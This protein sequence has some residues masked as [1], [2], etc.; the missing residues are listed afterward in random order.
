MPDLSFRKFILAAAWRKYWLGETGDEE[1]EE[2]VAEIQ[3]RVDD[4]LNLALALGIEV[5]ESERWPKEVE[6][7]GLGD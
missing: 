7:E 3:A 2:S 6:S 5:G 1:I 4:V